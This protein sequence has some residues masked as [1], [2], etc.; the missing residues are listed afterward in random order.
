VP[1]TEETPTPAEQKTLDT[2]ASDF[3]KTATA[4]EAAIAKRD[5]QIAT[6]GKATEEQAAKVN[7]LFDDLKSLQDSESA[8]RAKLRKEL[9]E[10]IANSGRPG[11]PGVGDESPGALFT[12]SDALKRFRE[13]QVANINMRVKGAMVPS[14]S[15]TLLDSTGIAPQAQRDPIIP[16]PSR[17]LTL[18]DLIPSARTSVP[19][20]EYYEEMGFS[21]GVGAAVT[22][23]AHVAGLA[24][25][26]MAAAHGWGY[27]GQK[28]N[29]T[30][31]GAVQA[32]YNGTFLVTITTTTAGTFAVD[33]GATTPA[34]GTILAYKS[35]TQG[36]AAGVAEG[37]LKPEAQLS[38]TLR[39]WYAQV[40]AHWLPVT[41]QVVMDNDQLRAMV[42]NRLLY[43]L[44]HKEEVD[45][46]Y[47]DGASPNL[48]GI[49]THARRQTYTWSTGATLPVPD[50]KIDAIRKAMTLA[51]IAE[52]PVT[53]G[54]FHPLDWQD[55]ELAKGDDG[56]YL[57]ISSI[58]NA[59]V[60]RFFRVPVVVTTAIAPGTGLVGA[61]AQAA[62][63]W[64]LEEGNIRVSDQHSDNFTK[65]LLTILA[66]ERVGVAWYRPEAFVEVAFDAA[67]S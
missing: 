5:E 46:L 9:D 32:D 19:S 61:F 14:R 11:A 8:E 25:I 34:T 40:I 7:K 1:P 43:G 67:P 26:T 3:Q 31:S 42:D 22:S 60:T 53:G 56:H 54:V 44:G 17:V 39:N 6:Q 2:L 23:I 21:A 29:V 49:L 18:R 15:K 57:V 36:A 62:Q 48:Q 58:D 38:F 55:I 30:I 28:V 65:N 35:Q 63:L 47:G 64:D 20:G 24:T 27:V 4:L 45:L 52:Y 12:N 41:R 13:S 33:S 51:Q 10:L 16:A 50:T 37:A 66:E 59:G